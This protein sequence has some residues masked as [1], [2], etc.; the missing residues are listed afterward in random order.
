MAAV[1][2]EVREMVLMW[3]ELLVHKALSPYGKNN[4][5]KESVFRNNV[6]EQGKCQKWDELKASCEWPLKQHCCE[7]TKAEQSVHVETEPLSWEQSLGLRGLGFAGVFWYIIWSQLLKASIYS[8]EPITKLSP[9][10]VELAVFPPVGYM[11]ET[12]ICHLMKK[13]VAWDFSFH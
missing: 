1:E 12:N 11:L 3:D 10:R 2:A 8:M 5:Q 7:E 6:A 13:V 4:F 9:W